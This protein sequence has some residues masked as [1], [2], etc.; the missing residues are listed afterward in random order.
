M[1]AT[2][3]TLLLVG[4]TQAPPSLPVGLPSG[5]PFTATPL[6]SM[7]YLYV[8]PHG[9]DSNPGSGDAPFRTISKAAQ[10]VTP[11]TTVRVAPGTYSE[12]IETT[13]DG[14]QD[15]RIAYVAETK[16]AAK[17]V[18]DG[19]GDA[20]WDNRGDYVDIV[21]FDIS[22]ENPDSIIERGSNVLIAENYL[23][24]A[25]GGAC[26][27]TYSNDYALA[28][29][30]II[31][32]VVRNCGGDDELNHGIYPAHSGG[33]IANNISYGNPGFGIHCW[34][35]CS[36]LTIS[37]NLVF[38]NGDGGILIGQG[39]AP[40]DGDVPADNMLVTNNIAVHN[41]NDGISEYGATGENNKYL[42][43]NV[44]GNKG[45]GIDLLTGTE[46]GTISEDPKFVNFQVNGSG[47]YRL[48]PSSPNVNAGTPEGAP[49]TDI[50]GTRR[51]RGPNPDIGVYEL[52]L[53]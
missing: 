44:F 28:N 2:F 30:D 6:S 24:D 9:D 10:E 51:P 3:A 1:L 23:H 38:D 46:T 33:T 25:P 48:D 49:T 11:G 52:Q 39:D 45:Q 50:T 35:A 37:N 41:G 12:S 42:N 40:N 21:G 5:A 20:V 4:C 53:D 29:I 19:D 15:A 14:E 16:W 27:F 8:A 26:L 22:G 13:V 31:G 17:I 36:N 32:N 47:D 43:N 34:H 18:G 7:R